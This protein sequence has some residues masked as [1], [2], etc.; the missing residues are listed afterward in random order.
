MNTDENQFLIFKDLTYILA[1]L[2][3][4]VR[5]M[6][7]YQLKA[8]LCWASSLAICAYRVHFYCYVDMF[9][10]ILVITVLLTFGHTDS[11]LSV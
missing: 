1:C 4:V 8:L 9:N 6:T 11:V 10:I 7:A 2:S 3:S 5:K